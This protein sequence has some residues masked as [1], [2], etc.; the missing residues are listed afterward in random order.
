MPIVVMSTSYLPYEPQQQRLLPD[1]LQ[2]WLPEGHLAYFC[3]RRLN[4]EP[5]WRRLIERQYAPNT[6]RCISALLRTSR[7]GREVADLTLAR[8]NRRSSA[9]C[10][11]NFHAV[12]AHIQCSAAVTKSGP[13][14]NICRLFWLKSAFSLKTIG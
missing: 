5:G 3:R 4:I 10:K 7:C 11:I 2:D 13:H 12:P 8:L 14:C 6:A 9:S 1:A